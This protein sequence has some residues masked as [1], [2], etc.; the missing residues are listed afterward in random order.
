MCAVAR[1]SDLKTHENYGHCTRRKLNGSRMKRA[2]VGT[3][4]D[5]SD[6]FFGIVMLTYE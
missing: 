3:V 5:L 4:S 6:W 1:D 2:M